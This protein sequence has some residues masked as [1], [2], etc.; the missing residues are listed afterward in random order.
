MKV[1]EYALDLCTSGN[2]IFDS[3][4]KGS[5]GDAARVGSAWG[6]LFEWAEICDEAC[7]SGKPL[8]RTGT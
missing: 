5:Y 1:F 7:Q 8:E 6:E 3:V 2:I 4:D